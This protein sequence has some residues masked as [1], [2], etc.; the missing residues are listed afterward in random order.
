MQ[1]IAELR[2]QQTT[3]WAAIEK[4]MEKPRAEKR[5]L[6]A[7][8][9]AAYDKA[10]ADFQAVTTSVQAE[11]TI[12]ARNSAAAQAE[13]ARI[14]TEKRGRTQPA[15]DEQR[16]FS[17]WLR[18]GMEGLDGEQRG[19]LAGMQQ[20]SLSKGTVA[21]GGYMVPT[22]FEA[23][24]IKSSLHYGGVVD[25]IVACGGKV[26]QTSDG[27][28]IPWPT[29][30][31]T[32]SGALISEN[33]DSTLDTALNTAF[34]Q[35]TISAYTFSSLMVKVS[36]VLLQDSAVDVDA[37]VA[38]LLTTRIGRSWNTYLTTGTGSSQP[39][40]VVVASTVGK[41][42]ASATAITAVELL[43]LIHSVDVSYRTRARLMLNDS[44]L[45]LLLKLVDGNSY[46]IFQPSYRDA[47]PATIHGY[48]FTINNDMDAATAALKSVLFGDFSYHKVRVAQGVEVQRLKERY[49]EAN[50]TA[51]L[52]FSRMD[53]KFIDASGGALKHLIQAA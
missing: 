53:A 38:D 42:A 27:Q 6:N 26:I 12:E 33:T 28:S 13:A 36:N 4:M 23:N 22:G 39:Q 32:T 51:F 40:G 21:A 30:N 11:E 16:A 49:A 45:K 1:R 43:D 3:V 10:F 18:H 31:D 15:D 37:L 34:G 9:A 7:E 19:A 8:E 25:A 48:P 5:A 46:P 2:Q 35:V 24:I 17:R 29:V 14:E 47:A 52:A 50:L 44:T 20:R 41:T